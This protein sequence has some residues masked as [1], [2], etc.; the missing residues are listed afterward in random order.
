MK[1]IWKGKGSQERGYFNDQEI[2]KVDPKYFRPTEVENLLGDASKANSKLNW[3][4]KISF[5]ELVKEMIEKDL[6]L[7]KNHKLIKNIN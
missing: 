2:I 5:E 6:E 1:I 4:P 7:T 3:R